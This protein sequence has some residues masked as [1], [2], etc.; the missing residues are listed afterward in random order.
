MNACLT[1]ILYVKTR[2]DTAFFTYYMY[3]L[4]S[5]QGLKEMFVHECP[6]A[7]FFKFR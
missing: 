2:F 6:E 1:D 7:E 3:F 4:L 5:K